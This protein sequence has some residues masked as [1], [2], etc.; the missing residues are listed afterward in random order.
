MLIRH[1]ATKMNSGH[2]KRDE[3]KDYGFKRRRWGNLDVLERLVLPE[4]KG[5]FLFLS[6]A[7]ELLSRAVRI[8]P[9]SLGE[10]AVGKSNQAN[11]AR[12]RTAA[13]RER[14]EAVLGQTVDAHGIVQFLPLAVFVVTSIVVVFFF[15]S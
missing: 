14:S 3:T 7:G 15:L 11:F 13:R 8:A 10:A 2:E 12:N 6:G 1:F 4:R 5:Q 9:A